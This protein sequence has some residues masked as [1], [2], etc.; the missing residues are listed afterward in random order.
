MLFKCVGS[1]Q[2]KAAT[3]K[4]IA[5]PRIV[6]Q[7]EDITAADQETITLAVKATG[8]E[9]KYE[10]QVSKDDGETW[11]ASTQDG[12][13]TDTLKVK[14]VAEESGYQYRC[15]VTNTV[16]EAVTDPITVTVEFAPK[17]TA[18][19]SD[20][21]TVADRMV[22]ASVEASGSEPLQYSWEYREDSSGEW[23]AVGGEDYSGED[24][25]SLTITATTDK[26]G[27]EYRCVVTNA[28]GETASEAAAL[29]VVDAKEG[30]T[31]GDLFWKLEDTGVLTVS[32][33]GPMNDLTDEDAWRP[34][35]EDITSLVIED[36]VTSVG[37]YAFDGCT[38]LTEAKLAQGITTIG[39][40]GFRNCSSLATIS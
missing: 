6:E 10:W 34:Y 32:G 33:N 20:M 14:A 7:P 38:A 1:V 2:S 5:P 13:K 31:W 28:A 25:S 35:R 4:V 23:K 12:A 29:T 22:A 27:N 9:I 3:L 11:T 15:A 18:Q 8:T 19:P 17:I 39:V 37:D 24:T 26:N 36:G 30:G 21:K 40:A 16:G